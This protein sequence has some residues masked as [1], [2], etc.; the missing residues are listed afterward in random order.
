MI[1]WIKINITQININIF[2]N[3]HIIIKITQIKHLKD[4]LKI[5]YYPNPITIILIKIASIR[6]ISLIHLLIPILIYPN[7]TLKSSILRLILKVIYS[8]HK[9]LLSLNLKI[10]LKIKADSKRNHYLISIMFH[11]Y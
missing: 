2:N 4:N 8:I 9:L 11:N 5:L 7:K 3:S 10:L 1:L 6:I